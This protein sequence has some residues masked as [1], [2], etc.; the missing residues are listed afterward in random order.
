MKVKHLAFSV[1]TTAA[2]ATFVANGEAEASSNTYKVKSGDSL[3]K[4]A[5]EHKLSVSEIKKINNLSSD[6]IFPGQNLSLSG[7]YKAPANNQSKQ[8]TSTAKPAS[9]ASAASGSVYTV[10]RGDTLSRIA[11]NN[12][13]SV[14][15]IKKLNNLKGDLILVGQKL[16][17]SSSAS[18]SSSTS[19]KAPA[20][21]SKPSSPAKAPA[22]LATGSQT[23]RVVSGDTLS[24]IAARHKTTV[25]NLQALNNLSGT[26]IYVG[27]TLKVNG[28]AKANG[29]TDSGKVIQT[30][31]PS[32]TAS[33]S[34]IVSIAKKYQGVPYKWGGTT[35]SGFDCSGFIYYV[36]KEAGLSN[37]RATAAGYYDRSFSVK[38]PQAGDFV[39]F[40][41]TY[42]GAN[43][44]S[45]MGIYLGNN[46]FIHASSS[47]GI[48]IS[49][50]NDS[51]WKK[52]PREFKKHY[53]QL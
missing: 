2:L 3:W 52:F 30:S 29:K 21:T 36:L 35:P 49:N 41:G 11:A 27:Q 50:V 13:M 32:S 5:T 42:G 1:L 6:I 28:T 8:Q 14:A 48:T 22:K 19:A 10:K 53:S 51:Y 25:K 43:N 34:N 33:T 20:Q 26:T 40:R 9:S 4:I 44:V 45:H 37:S 47:Q 17:L 18:T 46:Q 24:K 12:G 39:F 31:A 16:K 23:Y 15:N 38:S 7:T